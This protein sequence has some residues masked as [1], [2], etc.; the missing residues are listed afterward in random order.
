M[1]P[2][3]AGEP[4]GKNGFRKDGIRIRDGKAVGRA[5]GGGGAAVAKCGASRM[6]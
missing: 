5:G 6:R 1:T 3:L 4:R 2:P